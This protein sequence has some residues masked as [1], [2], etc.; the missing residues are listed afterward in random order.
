MISH[1]FPI[2]HTIAIDLGELV[3]ILELRHNT[4][5]I[6]NLYVKFH[7]FLELVQV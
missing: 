4:V 1:L 2:F 7:P 6:L 5:L 3:P